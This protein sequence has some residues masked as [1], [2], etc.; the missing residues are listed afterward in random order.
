MKGACAVICSNG[1]GCQPP[2]RLVLITLCSSA[3]CT[4]PCASGP[5]T[6]SHSSTVTVSF[7]PPSASSIS[8]STWCAL[9]S[10][11][12]IVQ[13]R[14]SRPDLRGARAPCQASLSHTLSCIALPDS[15]QPDP[16]Q[17]L[18]RCTSRPTLAGTAKTTTHL[19]VGYMTS[20]TWLPHASLSSA[21]PTTR[22]GRVSMKG[23]PCRPADV[24]RLLPLTL[25]GVCLAGGRLTGC[26]NGTVGT[27]GS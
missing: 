11:W 16:G 9:P 21:Q 13:E 1:H 12:T 22:A 14:C 23:P 15:C 2:T 17:G 24:A 27:G 10:L 3:T 20:W 18:P 6:L 25:T 7:R 19:P 4:V 8:G 26:F 5:L